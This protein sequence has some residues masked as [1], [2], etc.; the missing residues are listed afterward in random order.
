MWHRWHDGPVE[1]AFTDPRRDRALVVHG[2]GSTA[3]VARRLV[4][5]ILFDGA[6]MTY[7]TEPDC[8]PRHISR[9]IQRW[10]SQSVPPGRQFVAGISFGAHALA[11]A[12][13][14]TSTALSG[15]LLIMPAWTGP[16]GHTAALTQSAARTLQMSTTAA[17]LRRLMDLASPDQDWIVSALTSSWT[18]QPKERLVAGMSQAAATAGPTPAQLG[19]IATPTVIVGLRDDPLHP[20]D[21]ARLWQDAI[22]NARYVEVT[23]TRIHESGS[24]ATPEVLQAWHSVV[25]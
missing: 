22:P 24:F 13:S 25:A 11:M 6:A 4:P 20:V 14:G 18:S 15:A 21:T 19:T 8:R 9:A 7:L 5:P 3:G 23:T 10:Q 1:S 17:E 12:L 16:P 2:A